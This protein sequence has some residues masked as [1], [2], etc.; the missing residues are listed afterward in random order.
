LTQH[1]FA[2]PLI[3]VVALVA[4]AWLAIGLRSTLL[5]ENG[6]DALARSE[7]SRLAADD[8]AQALDDLDGAR[9]ANP[10]TTTRLVEARLLAA[11]GRPDAA[12]AV[13]EEVAAD[14]PENIEAWVLV[15]LAALATKDDRRAEHSLAAIRGLNPQLADR[16]A[17]GS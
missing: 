7:G 2:R 9:F 11:D 4:L 8:L 6:R 12:L 14:E 5:E 13:A 3:A 10:G 16:I 17:R 15:H 1:A